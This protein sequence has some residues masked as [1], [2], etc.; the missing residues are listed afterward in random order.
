MYYTQIVRSSFQMWASVNLAKLVSIVQ[1][2]YKKLILEFSYLFSIN[3]HKK[4]L[5]YLLVYD[6]IE[7]RIFLMWVVDW[8]QDHCKAPL[9]LDYY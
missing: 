9:W 4:Q 7:L 1:N 5:C 6:F 8:V 2:T 3:K